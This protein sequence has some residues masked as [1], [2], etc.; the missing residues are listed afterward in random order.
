M[1]M[2][3][4]RLCLSSAFAVATLVASSAAQAQGMSFRSVTVDASPIAQ[5]GRP[6]YARLVEQAVAPE[7]TAAFAD[8]ID[9][10][11]S[12]LRLV[13][14]I[15]SVFLPLNTGSSHWDSSDFMK[16]EAL[17][18]DGQGR[19]VSSTKVLSPVQAFTAP[20][21][22]VDIE[23]YRR[24]RALGQHAAYWLKRRLPGG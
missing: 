3:L 9:P 22:P 20:N 6:T 13:V 18:V 2:S 24:I 23:E 16:S 7:V 15:D 17:V 14:R 21:L 12:G 5:A 19:V 10:A 11:H 1:I 4:R 8:L